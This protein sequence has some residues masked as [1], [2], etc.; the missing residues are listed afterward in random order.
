MSRRQECTALNQYFR[1]SMQVLEWG[2]FLTETLS[3]QICTGE[4]LQIDVSYAA[5]S[6]SCCTSGAVRVDAKPGQEAYHI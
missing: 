6:I 5:H 2:L 4:T 1:V 3:F